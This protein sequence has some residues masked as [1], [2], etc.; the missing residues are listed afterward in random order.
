MASFQ[1][2]KFKLALEIIILKTTQVETVYGLIVLGFRHFEWNRL[3]FPSSG[4]GCAFLF[5]FLYGREIEA[6]AA[7]R[8]YRAG[9]FFRVFLNKLNTK[10]LSGQFPV[11]HLYIVWRSVL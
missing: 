7:E 6:E 9:L 1:I 10:S 11:S 2:F 4:Y 5:I 3:Y 8:N